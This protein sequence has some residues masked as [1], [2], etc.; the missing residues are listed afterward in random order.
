MA[1][2]LAYA[3]FLLPQ[4][5][6]AHPVYT[7]A[8]PVLAAEVATSNS[9]GFRAEFIGALRRLAWLLVPASILV[10]LVAGPALG[11]VRFGSFDKEGVS[12]ATGGLRAYTLGLMGF[13]AYMLL[14]RAWAA[15]GRTRVPGVVSLSTAAV[16]VVMMFVLARVLPAS[17]MVRMVAFTHSAIFTVAS[18][19]LGLLLWRTTRIEAI[20]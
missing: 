4:A 15:L 13:G 1:A 12:L 20:G 5:L 9:A 8:F 19:I 18:L 14:C 11:L 7:S 6:L 16:G 3:F 10:L 2:Q 17:D